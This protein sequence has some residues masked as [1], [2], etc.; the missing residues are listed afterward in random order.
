MI[1]LSQSR[2]VW[3]LKIK[4]GRVLW[5]YGLEPLVRWLPK[6]CSPL[7]VAALRL[8]GAKIGRACLIMPGVEVLMP[9]NLHL[10]DHVAIGKGVNIYNFALVS[11]DRMTVVSQGAYL[12]T[13][14]HDYCDR[15][16]PLV[17]S[18]ISIGA[19]CW[20]TADVF[21]A[22]GVSIAEGVVVAA[23]SVVTKTLADAWF[24]YGG[25]PCLPIKKRVMRQ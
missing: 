13:G 1:D 24:V 4:L 25:N 5:T 16:M 19:M 15:F 6:F 2:T 20:V 17:Y 18:P 21:V 10:S 12:C 11:I 14:S 9:W 8:M 23:R 22:P 3:P 7:R